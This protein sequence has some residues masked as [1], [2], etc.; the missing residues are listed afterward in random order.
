MVA[1][2]AWPVNTLPR[3][4]VD[5]KLLLEAV[6]VPDRAQAHYLI[7]VMRFKMGSQL[8]LFDNMTGEW[9]GE[10]IEAD[11]KHLQIKIIHHLNEKEAIPDLWLL[12][13]PIKKGRIDWIYEKACELGVARITP[14]ITQ[15]TIVD[16]VNLERLQAHIVEAAEQCGRTSLSEVSEACS[17]KQILADWPEERALFF[18]DETG[19]ESMISAITQRKGPAAI[20]IGPEGG[21]TDQ[22]REMIHQIQQAVPVS[23]GPRILRADTA[24]IA[25]AALWMATAGDW[26]KQPRQGND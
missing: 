21:F 16:R 4:Y 24:A 17:L 6:I 5:E 23:L 7:S 11:R 2:P 25:A 18:A 19:G 20:L 15:R 13:A 8:V 10:V 3:L 22:E 9:L 12:T 1:E 14:V 26:G